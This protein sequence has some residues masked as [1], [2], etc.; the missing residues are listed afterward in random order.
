MVPLCLIW[1]IRRERNAI[2]FE[3]SSRSFE[4]LHHFFLF[5]LYAWTAECLAPTVISFPVFLSRFSSLS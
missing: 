4:D 1:C 3:D 5:T 2:C